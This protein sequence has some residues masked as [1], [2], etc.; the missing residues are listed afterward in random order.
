[1]INVFVNASHLKSNVT[2]LRSASHIPHVVITVGTHGAVKENVD[3]LMT[4]AKH[5][6]YLILFSHAQLQGMNVK[7]TLSTEIAVMDFAV[8]PSALMIFK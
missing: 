7:E 2:Q 5:N 8:L 4:Y 6:G 3:I 1:M